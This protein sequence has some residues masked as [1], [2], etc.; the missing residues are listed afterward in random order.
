MNEEEIHN[1]S[2]E[3]QKLDI[4][5]NI[6][7]SVFLEI[8]TLLNEKYVP[9]FWKH[10]MRCELNTAEEKLNTYFI[11]FQESILN[12]EDIFIKF[13][14][15]VRRAALFRKSLPG[16]FKPEQEQLNEILRT[17]L[18]SQIPP[19]FNDVVYSF[20]SISFKVFANGHQAE[21][22]GYEDEDDSTELNDLKCNG[23]ERE[24]DNCRCQE[25]VC[26]FNKTNE[27]LSNL[28]LLDRLAGHT[29][30]SLIQ[31]RICTFVKDKCSG[32]FEKSHF[33]FL[34]KVSYL[35]V[36]QRTAFIHRFFRLYS[37]FNI[38]VFV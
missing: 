7:E 34:E 11:N 24:Q 36:F 6:Y 37:N 32:N 33:A 26:A 23:C 17:V 27:S 14:E 5:E 21:I 1:L 4:A 2:T 38:Y 18:L 3:L 31:D 15:I 35:F 22:E 19:H 29:L 13:S 30:T 10:L 28:G 12:L 20:Y 16:E 9:Q 25:L 8:K